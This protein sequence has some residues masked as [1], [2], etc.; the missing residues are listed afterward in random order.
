MQNVSLPD[1]TLLQFPDDMDDSAMQAAIVS[2]YPQFAP[3]K[4]MLEKAGD[5]IG[6]IAD[7]A[8]NAFKAVVTGDPLEPYKPEALAKR[9]DVYDPYAAKPGGVMADLPPQSQVSIDKF[10]PMKVGFVE[11]G[12]NKRAEE[13]RVQQV[14]KDAANYSAAQSTGPDPDFEMQKKFLNDPFYSNPAVRAAVKGYEGYKLGIAGLNEKL[15]T[16]IGAD[17]WAERAR[18]V[19]ADARHT[20]YSMGEN[21]DAIKNTFEGAVSSIAQQ[22]PAIVGGIATGSEPLVLGTMFLQ[23]FGQEY[24][25]G[26]A[27]GQSDGDATTRAALFGTFEML[28]EKFGLSNQLAGIKG[29]MRGAPTDVVL[30]NFAQALVKEVPGEEL[31]TLGQFMTDKLPGGVGL[32]SEAG[33]AEYLKQSTDTL[34]QTLM[35]GGLMMGGGA[36]VTSVTSRMG[37]PTPLNPGISLSSEQLANNARQSALDKGAN[38]FGADSAFGRAAQGLPTEAAPATIVTGDVRANAS[39]VAIKPVLLPTEALAK[40]D[41]ADNIDDAIAAAT[42]AASAPVTVR[43]P[44][45]SALSQQDAILEVEKVAGMQ[46]E[47]TSM[48]EAMRAARLKLVTTPV[49]KRPPV[50]T[51]T[52]VIA[53]QVIAESTPLV[54]PPSSTATSNTLPQGALNAEQNVA[55]ALPVRYD[56]PAGPARVETA[57]P[58]SAAGRAPLGQPATV[59]APDT[60]PTDAARALR[61][62]DP[63]SGLVEQPALTPAPTPT[64]AQLKREAILAPLSELPNKELRKMLAKDKRTYVKNAIADIIQERDAQTRLNRSEVAKK[65]YAKT[66]Q[67]DVDKDTMAQAIAKLGGINRDSA[68]GRMRLAPE[69]MNIKG[70]GLLPVFSKS[71]KTMDEMGAALAHLGYVQR[72]ENGKHDQSDYEEKLAETA[73]GVEVYTPNAIM[74]RAQEEQRLA[75]EQVG[76]VTNEEY[77]KI[78]STV[79]AI[80]DLD[81]DIAFDVEDARAVAASTLTDEEINGLFETTTKQESSGSS[82]DARAGNA[83][84][85][86]E[87]DTASQRD[88]NLEGESA[89]EGRARLEQSEA[90]QA[91]QRQA[92]KAAEDKTKA[93][94]EVDTFTLTGSNRAAD[95]AASQGQGDLLA[96]AKPNDT[97]VSQLLDDAGI[98]G[99]ERLEAQSKFRAGEYSL[100][101]L[102]AAYPANPQKIEDLGEKI[103]GA[104][105]DTSTSK[106]IRTP[107]APAVESPTW[108]KRF[109][110]SQ[111]VKDGQE[112]AWVL[113]DKR[114][115]KAVRGP[116][117][118]AQEFATERAAKDAIPL[119]ALS[120]KHRVRLASRSGETPA[121]EIWRD[122]TDRKRVKVVDQQFDSQEEAMRYMVENAAKILD[123]KTSFGEEILEKPSKVVRK[124]VQ[125]REGNI[126][127]KNLMDD[128]GFRGV[129]FGNWNSQDDRQEVMNHAY[130]ALHDLADVMKVPPRA[131]SLNGELGLAFGARGQGLSGARAHYERDYGAINLTKM[132]GAGAL[133][134]EWFHGL[135]HYLG[136]QDGKAKSVRVANESGD[137]VFQ[138]KNREQDYASHGFSYSGSKVRPEVQAAYSDLMKT[139]FKKAEKYVEDTEK[140]EKFVGSTRDGL[141]SM[142][143]DI[144]KD[145][146]Q[147]KDPQYWKRNNKPASAVQ[148]ADFD[149]HA[150]NLADGN[151]LNTSWRADDNGKNTRWSNDTLDAIS[152]IYKSVRGRSGF[153]AERNGLLDRVR[154]Q[155]TRYQQRIEMLQAANS[156]DEKTKHVPT[157]YAMDATRIDQGRASDYWATEHE[158]AARA[159]SAYVEDKVAATDGRSDFLSFGSD[160]N[161]PAYRMLNVRP[162]PEGAERV[163][164]N[165]AFDKFVDVIETKTDEA[166]NVAIYSKSNRPMVKTG[167]KV[168]DVDKALVPMRAKWMGFTKVKTVQSASDLPPDVLARSNPDSMTEG[169]YYE[170]TATV[171]LIA[172][173]LATTK[174]AAWV[175]AHEV[176]GHGGLRMLRDKKVTEAV[177]L[178]SKNRYV[179][180]LGNVIQQGRNGLSKQEAAEEAV[181]ELAAAIE[182]GNFQGL[183]DRYQLEVPAAYMNGVKGVVSRVIEALKRF[184]AAV[185]NQ[186]VAEVS[187]AEVRSLIMAA[188]DAVESAQGEQSTE[189]MDGYA[190]ASEKAPVF[191]SALLRTIPQLDKIADKNGMVGTDQARLW[192]MSRQK[193]GKFKAD[194]LAW[195]GL[196]DWLKAIGGKTTISSIEMYVKNNGVQVQEV[197]K[198]GG[199]KEESYKD[200][201]YTMPEE[202]FRTLVEEEIGIDADGLDLSQNSA[203]REEF[204]S[205]LMEIWNRQM[206]HWA[207]KDGASAPN[208]K[209]EAYAL[210]GGK[211]YRELLLTL[212]VEESTL[213]PGYTVKEVRGVFKVYGPNDTLYGQATDRQAA[214]ESVAEYK[215]FAKSHKSAH[216]DEK[217]VIA[218]IRFNDRTDA[219]G[220][221]VLFIEEIQSDW[222]QEGKKKGFGT[223]KLELIDGPHKDNRGSTYFNFRS[224][225]GYGHKGFGESEEWARKDVYANVESLTSGVVAAPFVTD[226]KSWLALGIKRMIRYAAENGYDRVAFI[227]GEQSADRYDLSQQISRVQLN[228]N[229]SGGIGRP[230]MDGEFQGGMV[231]AYDLKG[232]EVINRRVNDANELPGVVGKEV[233]DR[234]LNATPKEGRFAGLGM[235]VRELQGL[236]LKVG[237]DGMKT[238]Y[239][240]IVPQVASDVLKKLGGKVGTIDM[241]APKPA[242]DGQIAFGEEQRNALHTMQTGFDITS[243]MRDKALAGQPLFSRKRIDTDNAL[244]EVFSQ[245]AQKDEAYSLPTTQSKSL[246]GAIKDLAPDVIFE[247]ATDRSDIGEYSPNE[248]W[249]KVNRV[250]EVRTAE[251]VN[252]FALI[253][254]TTDRKVWIDISNWKP[255][256]DGAAV[257]QAVADYAANTG[258]AFEADPMGMSE[259]AAYRRLEHMISSTL[260]HGTTAHL[261]PGERQMRSDPSLGDKIRQLD[262]RQGDDAHNLSEMLAASYYNVQK[263]IPEIDD[264]TYNFA[265]GRFEAAPGSGVRTRLVEYRKRLT[266][267]ASVSTPDG[268]VASTGIRSDSSTGEQSTVQNRASAGGSG[269]IAERGIVGADVQDASN[270][271]DVDAVHFTETDFAALAGSIPR[272]SRY[273]GGSTG[274]GAAQTVGVRTLKRAILANSVLRESRSGV[275]RL[276]LDQFSAKPLQRL[277]P[278]LHG[279]LYSRAPE[280]QAD[281]AWKISNTADSNKFVSDKT[282]RT[283]QNKMIDT[284][285]VIQAISQQGRDILDAFDPYL[286]EELYYGRS[287][288]QVTDF[289]DKEIR[290][291]LVDMQAR[292]ITI[293]AFE[294]YLHM[295]HAEERNEQIATINEEMPDGGSGVATKDARDY[296]AGLSDRQR[297][298][299]TA[300]A[301]RIDKINAGTQQLLI[302]SGLEKAE[303]IE[304]WNKTYQ[305]YVPL[306]RDDMEGG[307]GTGQGFSVG[308]PS[309][310]RAMGS[311]RA[312]VDILAN[313][314]MQRERTITR[315]EKNRIATAVYGLA[316][317]SPN[318]DFWRPVNPGADIQRKLDMLFDQ[319]TVAAERRDRATSQYQKDLANESLERIDG[320][321]EKL[322]A[323]RNRA[324]ADLVQMGVNQLDAEK[325]FSEPT[326]KYIDPNTGMVRERVNNYLRKGD[327]VLSVRIKGEDR[328]VFF[329]ERDDVAMNMVAILKNLDA[330]KLGWWGSRASEITR[331]FAAINTQYNPVFGAYNFARDV[332]GALANLSTTPIAGQQ[333]KVA[334]YAA[335][336]LRA[337]YVDARNRRAGRPNESEWSALYDE[338][339]NEGGQ[340]GFKSMY[341]TSEERTNAIK[342]ELNPQAWMESPFGKL[343]TA[344]GTLRVP[345][346]MVQKRASGVMG[347]LSDYNETAENATR[348]A[349]YKAAKEAGLSNQRAASIAKNISVNF[350]R[351]GSSAVQIGALYA[352]FNAAVQGTARMHETLTGP[353]GKQIVA[354]GLLLGAMQAFALAAAGYD[355]DEIPEFVKSRNLI[356]PIGNGKYLAWPLPLGF[357]ILPNIGRLT[358]EFALRGGKD[359]TGAIKSLFNQVADTLSPVGNSGF[360]Q[361]LSF[362]ALDP[363]VALAMNEDWT[364]RKI[365]KEDR[366]NLKETPGF[367]RAKN[368]ASVFGKAISYALNISSGGTDYSPG[369]LSPTPDQIDYLVGQATGG[370]GREA[371]KLEESL[372]SLVTGEDLPTYKIPVIGRMYG[373]V[374]EQAS[375]SAKF[376][377]N[378]KKINVH[379]AEIEGR[380]IKQISPE[381]YAK[382]HP[383]SALIETANEAETLVRMLQK[384]KR[385]M[386]GAGAGKA[387]IKEVEAA[388]SHQ[389]AGFNEYVD[390]ARKSQVP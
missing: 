196:D 43:A 124:G 372:T 119:A 18:R 328:F 96:P 166:G 95:I 325:T 175:A 354:G 348:L 36:A 189:K 160:N 159:F 25:D 88:F 143:D 155:M 269:S 65:V 248:D 157:S 106:G 334:K 235:R 245:I 360:I 7:S 271:G 45:L 378:V 94:A 151:D 356:I 78:E 116:G 366:D 188:R 257:Y 301:K 376:Y 113:I 226:T 317:T 97:A 373:D 236:D 370:V 279:V 285:R 315:A 111:I 289:L 371:M 368:T 85:G 137:M 82:E 57:Q 5:A 76:A 191:Y 358:T 30:K 178:A 357:N 61:I 205:E 35:Q 265:S 140:A 144:R 291:M 330:E 385:E 277:S 314:T 278:Q 200:S 231:I 105:K 100:N 346:S 211:N 329:N 313:I 367:T 270:V 220:K 8:G 14:E 201:L 17:E 305:Y 40:L 27:R 308:G 98:L 173:N 68:A 187:D 312:V 349:A 306:M 99:K 374:N 203:E 145:L 136:R 303:T 170:P 47:L 174:R 243:E 83:G 13:A 161:R 238:F 304:A 195:S 193:E 332:Q 184:Y 31:T 342:K 180:D 34:T 103:G 288:K 274:G 163:A 122:V 165:Q 387:D 60:R 131:L 152:A 292:G 239:D 353:S 24:S 206:T 237:G 249:R 276:L 125:R 110:P 259:T 302:D 214:I 164:I 333:A 73:G 258:K 181:A 244:V 297:K 90:S 72:D 293:E 127:G 154:S 345:M 331:Y 49:S 44:E 266:D 179:S 86:I 223:P 91:A 162:F 194:E 290:P 326:E 55:T 227:S 139:M 121:F 215:G 84:Q 251:D 107:R 390:H 336:A 234:L 77:T 350:N 222:G 10:D 242:D 26:R 359:V 19:G 32:N 48:E 92:D 217:N 273:L 299:F 46:S 213:P 126:T 284:R 252:N 230:Q 229:S 50:I 53:P 207:G 3:E 22:I 37:K 344:N 361:T 15:A 310:K 138:A 81:P 176:I 58:D 343:F 233:A 146:E 42:Q 388:I 340:T 286:Q 101:D 380:M 142:L 4:G 263:A 39:V 128:F 1:G 321:V 316:V 355:D 132:E 379:E 59:G 365:A 109:E 204:Y 172:D 156:G 256:G 389:M 168:A 67:I 381:Q 56:S 383:E 324:I 23:S 117:Y 71:G 375:V 283:L 232:E 64:A 369:L 335:Q 307:D 79:Q 218:H 70:H 351:K 339:Q 169:F 171:Y 382:D 287:A 363:F 228:D 148:I 66:K 219:D 185:T 149:R 54:A 296:L 150:Q 134:H 20:S 352:F 362:T 275:G 129:E 386:I 320:D 341:S 267:E 241:R 186:P 280:S 240:K 9:P 282:I 323:Q 28:G 318:L 192:L 260:R 104:R 135:D 377:S 347:W 208:T 41:A 167:I 253:F 108:A 89:D 254:E 224:P 261:A 2:N 190:M 262:W 118:K 69:E 327:N 319:R 272:G 158:M 322:K 337:V 246:S 311:D 198:G 115:D 123:V 75:M 38:I 264:V 294:E 295:R 16:T 102:E 212:P 87:G 210:P 202:E 11:A 221:Q 74:I 309:T 6:Q 12:K 93:D 182:T 120:L 197:M 384:Q 247:D 141:R 33:M 216:W 225:D 147:Q 130:D 177:N 52:A 250:S 153:N 199:T 29:A 114:L 112:G 255:G 133:A 364:G 21:P 300:L 268:E 51:E 63:D 183:K 209:Y 298:A 80:E 281:Q 62:P 338:F